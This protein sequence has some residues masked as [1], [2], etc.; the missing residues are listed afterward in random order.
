[1][2]K[3][4]ISALRRA[5]HFQEEPMK[6]KDYIDIKDFIQVVCPKCKALLMADKDMDFWY[7]GHCG[8]KLDMKEAL[9]AKPDVKKEKP[10][11]V[12]KGEIF[13]REGDTLYKYAG[14]AEDVEIPENIAK[15]ASI[16]GP[17]R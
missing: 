9:S 17:I 14:D 4:S 2:K 6:F 1:M 12:L 5:Y 11:P 10:A 13:K 7:C 16:N 15:I 3:C 8:N